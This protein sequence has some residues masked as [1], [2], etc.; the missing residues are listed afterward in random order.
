M[1][2][3]KRVIGLV[4]HVK[5]SLFVEVVHHIRDIVVN[6]R[7]EFVHAVKKTDDGTAKAASNH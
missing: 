4:S 5:V 2:H 3:S 1:Q 7:A 6:A